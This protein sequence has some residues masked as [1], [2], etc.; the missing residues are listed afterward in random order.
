[1]ILSVFIIYT[2]AKHIKMVEPK[3]NVGNEDGSRC[4]MAN[5][6][7]ERLMDGDV[8]KLTCD[9]L[10]KG[11]LYELNQYRKANDISWE[12]FYG[13]ILLLPS[14]KIGTLKVTLSRPDKSCA[15]PSNKINWSY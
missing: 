6:P 8:C 5:I 2:I 15:K 4:K 7:I 11:I 14:T 3:H 12:E 13:W 1:M 10:T 9:V